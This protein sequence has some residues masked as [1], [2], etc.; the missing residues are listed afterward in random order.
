M[1]VRPID[2]LNRLKKAGWQK[3]L[4]GSKDGPNCLLGAMAACKMQANNLSWGGAQIGTIREDIYQKVEAITLEQ[5]SMNAVQ[6]NDNPRIT[7][8]DIQAVL[9]KAEANFDA[10]SD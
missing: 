4:M 10:I 5:Y 9:E 3:S 7:F 2:V 6:F 1:E 8:A